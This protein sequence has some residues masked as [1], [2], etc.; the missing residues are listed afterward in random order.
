MELI[1]QM[2]VGFS[3][4]MALLL[5]LALATGYRNV[6][7]P[8][9]S[10][11]A[12][13]V[14]LAGLALTQIAHLDF[15]A[16]AEGEQPSRRYVVVVFLQSLGFYW[17]LLGA[18]RPEG[19]WRRVEW[20][21]PFAVLALALAIPLPWAIPVALASGTAGA[22]HLGLLVYRLRGLRRWFGLELKVLA[23]FAVMAVAVAV[24]GLLAPYGLGWDV[25]AWIYS[26]LIALG[27][28]VVAWLLL[29]VP[30]LV[31]KTREAVAVAYAQSTLARVDRDAMA[32]RL[33]QLFETER[34]HREESLNLGTAGEMLGL[35]THQLSELVNTEFGMG[36][37]RL[38]RQYRVDD[39]R[40]MLVEEPRASVLSIGL[41]AGFSSQST[42]YVAFKELVG[43]V[44]GAYRQRL[45]AG[46]GG[47]DAPG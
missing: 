35:S 6:A 47:T 4:G 23:L 12:G 11:V 15:A 32:T 39:A 8:W 29:A 22:L 18:L 31:P 21:L 7:L 10:R 34:V 28:G 13:F 19:E 38:V 9:P 24:S 17:L 26:T 27:F 46:G 14:M 20:A 42:F 37:P 16:G 2:L 43:E 41:A 1:L 33:R 44:P 5:A 36:F 25:Y 40:R 30:D 45:L 3:V